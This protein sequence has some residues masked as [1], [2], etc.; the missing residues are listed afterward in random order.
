MSMNYDY[1]V[2]LV[3]DQRCM[4]TNTL[5]EAVEQAIL[6]GCTM[7]Q[8]REKELD[9]FNFYCLAKNI[10]RVTDKSMRQVSISDK[11]T[12]RRLL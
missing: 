2:Y 7:I 3:T 9:S 8:L 6:G 11:M 12:F 10:K 5:C 4:S 1:S